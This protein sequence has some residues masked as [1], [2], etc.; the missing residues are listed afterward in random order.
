MDKEKKD[1]K[2]FVL[3]NKMEKGISYQGI[4]KV[5]K[6]GGGRNLGRGV[7]FSF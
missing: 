1:I 7:K 4:T 3:S 6:I 2:A 5:E